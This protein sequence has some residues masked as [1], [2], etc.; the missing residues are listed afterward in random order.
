MRS[1]IIG[2]RADV[3]VLGAGGGTGHRI[4]E[5]ALRHGH[6]VTAAVR[7][8]G[9]FPAPDVSADA[10][11]GL[12]VVH[13][14]VRDPESLRLAIEGQDVVVSAVGP[15]GR[16]AAGLY[17]DGARAVVAAMEQ[18]GVDR[19]LGI[20]SA[21]VRYDDPHLALWYRR[22]VRPLLGELY[23]DMILMERIVR[24]SSLDWTFV[25]PVL[26]LDRDPTGTYRVLDGATPERGRTITRGDVAQFIVRELD[27]RRWSRCAPTLAL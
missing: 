23:A 4:V 24:T 9:R 10:A 22:L 18:G 5:E 13:A 8:P 26:L 19:F 6:R 17:S 14:D 3:V 21:G 7:S 12:R 25:R 15:P 16:R 1:R 27:E 11:A 2:G 20:T